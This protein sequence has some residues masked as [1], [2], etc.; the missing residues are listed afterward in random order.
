MFDEITAPAD[1]PWVSY[2]AANPS[3]APIPRF[4]TKHSE[5]DNDGQIIYSRPWE[6]PYTYTQTIESPFG[7]IHSHGRLRTRNWLVLSSRFQLNAE[8]ETILPLLNYPEYFSEIEKFKTATLPYF[9]NRGIGR[10]IANTIHDFTGINGQLKYLTC[11][12]NAIFNHRHARPHENMIGTPAYP[13]R[14]NKLKYFKIDKN[15]KNSAPE[16]LEF[17]WGDRSSPKPQYPKLSAVWHPPAGIHHHP[18]A[19]NPLHY[20]HDKSQHIAQMVLGCLLNWA[21]IPWSDNAHIHP[22][23]SNGFAL[24]ND[25]NGG[26]YSY[27]THQ[28]GAC[29]I[30]YIGA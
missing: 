5:V 14:P 25:G 13:T 11:A 7:P 4:D 20:L 26:I 15:L 22:I 3:C 9:R 1:L 10:D 27:Y 6:G 16:Y 12:I 30:V 19:K 21:S 29:D 8:Y 17:Y 24:A 2:D 28:Q 23:Q 18:Y